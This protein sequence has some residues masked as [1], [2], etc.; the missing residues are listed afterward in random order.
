MLRKWSKHRA[1]QA[2]RID[3]ITEHDQPVNFAEI[4]AQSGDPS[5]VSMLL[6]LMDGR[7]LTATDLARAAGIPP[8]FAS[9]R[10]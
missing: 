5:R 9:S 4:A 1:Q 6:A 7:A 8:Q 10:G 3:A 2:V